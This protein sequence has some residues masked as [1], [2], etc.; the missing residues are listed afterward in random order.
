MFHSKAVQKI[1]THIL[2]S[3]TFFRKSWRLWQNVEKYCRAEQATDDNMAHAHCMVDTKGYKRTYSVCVTFIACPLQQWL[4]KRASMLSYTY[5]TCLVLYNFIL[6]LRWFINF[7][8]CLPLC[9]SFVPS[10]RVPLFLSLCHSFSFS[11]SLSFSSWSYCVLVF[12]TN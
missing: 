11:V 2:G 7:L 8:L 12:V 3:V 4:H 10:C 5:I 1:K 9:L 6:P